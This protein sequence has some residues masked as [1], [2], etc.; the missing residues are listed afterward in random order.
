MISIGCA[1]PAGL[2]YCY[3]GINAL[4]IILLRCAAVTTK[5]GVSENVNMP[6]TLA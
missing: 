3:I 6:P 5:N 2:S 4:G 1:C